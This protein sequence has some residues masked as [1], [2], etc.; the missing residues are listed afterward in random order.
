MELGHAINSIIGL[1][2]V[3]IPLMFLINNT[4]SKDAEEQEKQ[5]ADEKKENKK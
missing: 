1:S 3:A 5:K 2:F 4:R